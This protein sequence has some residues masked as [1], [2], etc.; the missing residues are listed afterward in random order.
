M[1]ENIKPNEAKENN[2]P[3]EVKPLVTK[4]RVPLWYATKEI[5]SREINLPVVTR[6]RN[7]LNKLHEMSRAVHSKEQSGTMRRWTTVPP[8]M[9]ITELS[10]QRLSSTEGVITYKV[11]KMDEN[12][13][14]VKGKATQ[15]KNSVGELVEIDAQ[16]LIEKEV[17]ETFKYREPMK[18][19]VHEVQ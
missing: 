14:K 1:S 13:N 4:D 3:K 18:Q 2:V 8:Q 16:Y 9:H 5:T 6:M 15:V 17:V 19:T 7:R 10:N 11:F 12:G